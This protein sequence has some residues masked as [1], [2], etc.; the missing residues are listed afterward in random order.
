MY[1]LLSL[2]CFLS[3]KDNGFPVSLTGKHPQELP[4]MEANENQTT[5]ICL[6]EKLGIFPF[7]YY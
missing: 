4:G 7:P 3:A 1:V 2:C 6:W 5:L